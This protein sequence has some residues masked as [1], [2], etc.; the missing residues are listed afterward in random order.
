MEI[1]KN[2][3]SELF[4]YCFILILFFACITCGRSKPSVVNN[5]TDPIFFSEDS[6]VYYTIIDNRIKV[7]IKNSKEPSIFDYFEHVELIPLETNKDVLIG[8]KMSKVIYHQNRYYTLDVQQYIIH[9]FDDAGKFIFKID[10]RGRGPGEYPFLDD[11]IINPFTGNLDL[12]CA[13]GFVY[14]YDLLGNYI[15]TERVSNS[16]LQAVHRFIA[17]SD[18]IYVFYGHAQPFKIIY[19]DIEKKKI[20]HQEYEEPDILR[21]IAFDSPFY[22]YQGHSYFYCTFNNDTYLVD[23]NAL[24]K[25][26]DWDFGKLNYDISRVDKSSNVANK[27]NHTVISDILERTPYKNCFQ[28]QNNRY[29]MSEILLNDEYVN[30]MFDKSTQECKLIYRFFESVG[31]RPMTVTNKYVLSYCY[32]GEL[33]KYITEDMLDETNQ[34]KLEILSEERG[35]QNNPVII[36]YYFK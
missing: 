18:K 34:Q 20:L 11:M 7:D 6:F 26:Y 17:I 8:G 13:Y 16:E 14:N 23:Q 12:L 22:E 2:C 5:T 36:K 27:G 4:Q 19:Y 31:L 35:E 29:V 3:F 28:G 10:K 15:K 32:P 33:Y 21:Y 24:V 1:K 25:A 30:L 9:V